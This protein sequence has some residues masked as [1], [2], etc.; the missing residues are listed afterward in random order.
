V[1]SRVLQSARMADRDHP[2]SIVVADDYPDT[3]SLMTFVLR[4]EG[5]AVRE[6][7]TGAQA[8]ALAGELPSLMILDVGLPDIDGFEVCRRVKADPRTAATA[9]LQVSAAFRETGHRV[10]ALNEGA[11]AYLTMPVDRQELLATVRALLRIRRAEAET[12]GLRAITQ[13]ANAAGHEINN[14][15]SVIT[16]HLHFLAKNPAVAAE[17]VAQME[18]AASRIREIVYQMLSVTRVELAKQ[19]HDYPEMLDLDRSS[20]ERRAS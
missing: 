16:G 5:F 17:R 18:E 19:H 6:A 2:P 7:A 9:V 15:L 4:S 12:A 20:R 3:R 10:R 14:P 13:L 1:A 8:L 11:D